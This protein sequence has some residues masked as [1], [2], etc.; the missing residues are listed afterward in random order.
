MVRACGQLIADWQLKTN[1]QLST[2]T[3]HG[4]PRFNCLTLGRILNTP[5]ENAHVPNFGNRIFQDQLW[6]RELTRESAFQTLPTLVSMVSAAFNQ[7]PNEAA[8][9]LRHRNTHGVL[10][11]APLSRSPQTDWETR[12]GAEKS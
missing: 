10:G 11:S 1:D 12:Q 6:P 9:L 2:G 3:W 8:Q 7:V 4:V 5:D